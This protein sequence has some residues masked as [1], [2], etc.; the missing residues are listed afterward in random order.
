MRIIEESGQPEEDDALFDAWDE[1]HPHQDADS[2]SGPDPATGTRVRSAAETI[3]SMPYDFS[4]ARL[5]CMEL[6]LQLGAGAA[7]SP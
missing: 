1:R 7:P 6:A 5:R 3:R 4:P 2:T